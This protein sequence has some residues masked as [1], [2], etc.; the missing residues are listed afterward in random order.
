MTGA[1]RWRAE[2]AATIEAV[3]ALGAEWA[4][5]EAATPEA[6]GFQS[7][8][9]CRIWLDSAGENVRPR[10]LCIREDAR[11]VMLLPLQIER[12]FGVSIARWLGEPMTQY[13][14]ALALP[15]E[16]RAAWRAAAFAEM[17][18][19]KDVDLVA[20]T[21]LRADAVLADGPC[22]G[23]EV[24][25]PYIALDAGKRRRHKS[26][27]RR[28]KR[29]EAQGPLSLEEAQ[30]P[31]ERERLAGHALTLKRDWLRSKG[32][33]SAG[34]SSP[35]STR[36]ITAAARAGVL[37][38]NVLRVGETVAAC[39]LGI[40]GGGAY[41]TFLGSFDARFAEGSPG[42]CLTGRVIERCAQE[43]LRAYDFLL[44]ADAYKLEWATGQT[45]IR[46]RFVPLSSKG[47]L[48]AFALARLRPLA[49]RALHALARLRSRLTGFSSP[50]GSTTL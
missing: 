27:E 34:L 19:W 38:V 9:W 40:V 14:D 2:C 12:R 17:A 49:K 31:A 10:V 41:R 6:T 45:S 50:A 20:L 3:D 48:A 28:A 39:D 1:T 35:T 23:E 42:Q 37:Q 21:R 24:C 18:R 11:L 32:I 44:P 7:F 36:F 13:G 46:A 4:A 47:R 25:A 26:V 29:L 5:L 22:D 15:G 16:G 8:Q 33:Y 43:G 30:S